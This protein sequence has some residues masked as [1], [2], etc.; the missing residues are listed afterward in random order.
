MKL[1]IIILSVLL[2][3]AVLTCLSMWAAVSQYRTECRQWR[4]EC[5]D[6]KKKYD[7]EVEHREW[8]LSHLKAQ[9]TRAEYLQAQINKANKAAAVKEWRN[10]KNKKKNN[11]Q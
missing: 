10:N 7:N 1:A 9:T 5:Q 4:T 2:L 3:V 6:V 11:E 8:A